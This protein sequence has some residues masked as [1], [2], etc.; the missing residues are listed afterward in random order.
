MSLGSSFYAALSGMNTNGMAMQVISDN[1]ANSNTVGF[2]GSSTQFEDI[3]GMSLEGIAGFTHIGVGANVSAMPCA[4]TQGTLMTTTVGTDVAVNGKGFFIVEDAISNEQFYTRA[5]NFHVDE[6]GYFVNVNDLRVQ[7]Y[8][9]DS[10]GTNLIEILDD[11]VVD[12]TTMVPPS[13]TG[14]IEMVLNLDSAE[15]ALVFDLNDPGA[16]S[17]YSTALTIYDTLGQSH[18]ITV[19]F[20]KTAPQTWEW[21]ATIDGSDVSGGTPGTAELFGT[22][23]LAFDD[24][25][26]LQTGMPQSFLTNPLGITFANGI[27][28]TAIDVD[29]SSTSQYG[30]PS[31]IQILTQDG[32]AAG[33][34]SGISIVTDGNIVGHFTNGQVKNIA[35]LALADF[36]SYMGLERAG[37]LLFKQTTDSG[38]P[39]VGKPSDAGMGEVS[40]GMLEES[41]VDLAS[42]F[43]K[44]I[45]TQRAYQANS[46]V[47]STT[48]EMLAQ[49]MSIK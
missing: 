45:V 48:D 34:L 38:V 42:E 21:N 5:G 14:E 18:T 9:Y 31:V 47:I 32:Y 41:N 46:K 8:L 33:N 20:T 2:K 28:A 44:M 15:D 17:N 35:R 1:I 6:E 11:I 27:D 37:S 12:Q 3:L 25:G 30:S 7:G 19:Y 4:F 16:T 26:V 24:Y 43:I 49:L 36:P 23:A 10:T 29:Y 22:G 39:L 13:I 40:A